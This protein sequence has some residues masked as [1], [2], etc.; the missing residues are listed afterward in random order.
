MDEREFKRRTRALSLRI[1]Q[2]VST[3]PDDELASLLGER[4]LRAGTSVGTHYRAACRGKSR[5]AMAAKLSRV[6]EELD[7]TIYWIRLLLDANVV[8]QDEIEGLL[9][10]ADELLA[11]VVASLQTLNGT[12]H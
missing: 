10:E 6:E 5:A 2:L 12:S 7:A 1:I 3:L 8:T 11:M 4:L 9:G